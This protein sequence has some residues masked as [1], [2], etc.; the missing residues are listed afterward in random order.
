[1]TLTANHNDSHLHRAARKRGWADRR[2]HRSDPAS[3][4]VS[5]ENG[6]KERQEEP[7]GNRE[8]EKMRQLQG[9]GTDELS[10]FG[11]T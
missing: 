1:M 6:E 9:N 7:E 10:T 3:P 8:E 11:F 5:V 2:S 4:S